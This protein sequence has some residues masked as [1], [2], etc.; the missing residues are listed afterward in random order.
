MR[1]YQA[2][3]EAPKPKYLDYN[4]APTPPNPC[5]AQ[6][7][8]PHAHTCCQL[9]QEGD[10]L[11]SITPLRLVRPSRCRRRRSQ[12]GPLL[13]LLLPL[14]LLIGLLG[15]PPHRAGHVHDGD[16]RVGGVL[17]REV[18]VVSCKQAPG[19]GEEER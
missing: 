1:D 8:P 2:V 9:V 3:A 15:A 13:W 16:A 11:N 14:L 4:A 17:S 6:P 18:V 19:G 5:A 10:L 12:P 7:V